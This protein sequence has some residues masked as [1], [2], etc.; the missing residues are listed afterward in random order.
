MK[1]TDIFV[2][3]PVLA[4]AL[5]LVILLLG[6]QAFTQM[7]IREYPKLT[8][9]MVTIT[10][11]YPG[12]S[13]STVQGFITTRLERVIASAPGIDYMTSISSEGASTITAYMKLNY[14]PDAAVANIQSKVQQVVNQLPTGA[15]LPI[16]NV[17]VGDPTAL[18]YIAFYGDKYSQQQITDYLLRVVQPKL[19][20]VAGV[21][22]AQILPA[23]HGNGNTYAMRVWL[24][25]DEMAALGVTAAD[26]TKAL[27]ANDYISAVGRTHGKNVAT[28]IS[29]TT[30]LHN[31]AEFRN[32]V[33]KQ[34]GNTLVRLKDVAK[35]QLGA[36]N[37]DSEAFFDGKTA[38]FI[39]I[40]PSPSANSLDVARGVKQALKQINAQL[41][42]GM[43]TAIPYDAS[44]YISKS[45]H[46][47]L[48]TVAITLGVVVL[49][50]FLSLGSVRA[51]MIPVVAI[52]LA[53]IGGGFV[54]WLMGF[55]VNLLTLLAIV[56]A[57]GLVVDDAIIVV[58]NVHRHIEEG[59]TPFEAALMTGRELG[60]PIVVMS[61]TLIAV[62]API[63]FMG[64]FTGSLFSEFAF[65]LVATVLVSM[66]VA[67]TLSPML[68]GKVLRHSK[69]HGLVHFIDARFNAFR[70]VYD[71]LLHG[72]LKYV[73]VT[74][75]FAAA[76]LGS[77]YFLFTTTPKELAPKEDQGVIFAMGTAQPTATASY[78]RRYGM[79]I[80]HDFAS[81]PVFSKSFMVTGFV[82]GGGGTNGLFA[83]MLLKPWSQ[84]S[85]TAMQ[86]E[87]KVQQMLG[88]IPGLQ[89]AAFQKPALPGSAGGL[90][91]QFVIQSSSGYHKINTVANELIGRAYKS[92]LFMYVTKDLKIDNPEI[93]LKIHRNIAASL[94]LT[95]QAITED[96]QPLLGGNLINRFDM[97][98][99]SYEVIPQVPDKFRAN[100]DLLKQYYLQ[101]ASGKLVPASTVVSIQRSVQPE[102]LP[103]FQQQNSA[104]I[105]AIPMPGVTQG[106]AL[107]FLRATAKQIFPAGF[108]VNYASESRQFMQEKGGLMVTFVLAVLLIY[109]LLAAQFESFRDPWIVLI[110][111]PMSIS[112]ALIFMS[113]GL[114]TIN[115]YTE[116]GLITLIGLI[117]K[118]GILI[119][120]FANEIQRNE[121]LDKRA[122]VEKASSIRL[123]PILMTTG[124]M[125]F[126]VVPLLLATGPGAVS[127]FDMGL[128]IA[129]GLSI[130]SL[131]SLFVVPA[132]YMLMAKDLTG[133]YRAR[134]EAGSEAEPSAQT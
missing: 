25:P 23:G 133:E 128:V 48:M 87:P 22:Q 54:M 47:V 120:Q 126:G 122:A 51:V 61:T 31:A 77:I 45:I 37:Y 24:N 64:G 4:T 104:T 101:T 8:N 36:E 94:G 33:I 79:M 65:T 118:Q 59:R 52:P 73:P 68:S 14:S 35:V 95:M 69:E 119:V 100:P 18:M 134:Q 28:M 108:S 6:L 21:S 116:V 40:Q 90:P 121:G 113:L 12:A 123:R 102:Y 60:G 49:V 124:A 41:P 10:T 11:T 9:S 110:T 96:L 2:R 125:V 84:R 99:R 75:V 30:S 20:S 132:M 3:R 78:L 32:L 83:G 131:F 91:V 15:Q 86:V 92:G 130:G 1:F 106:E 38:A 44:T 89:V 115:I 76:I 27:A 80:L 53:I 5:S 67:L 129:A 17:T 58:E 19:A 88:G 50:I 26:V 105:Q 74:L 46:E 82:P 55:S 114:A 112:G 34:T 111:V 107:G 70:A 98:G 57:I 39:G 103:Q 127:R 43:H 13:P 71:R 109:L 72:S 16:V 63:G 66:I 85:E 7:T 42:P 81:L 56:L 97:Q 93:V 29:A 117:A 62:F